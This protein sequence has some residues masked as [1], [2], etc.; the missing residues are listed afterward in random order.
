MAGKGYVILPPS[1]H[2]ETGKQYRWVDSAVPAAQLP[3]WLARLLQPPP[4][5]IHQ[6]IVRSNG[7]DKYVQAALDGEVTD[8]ATAIKGQRNTA[9]NVAAV[10]LGTLVGAGILSESDVCAA[11]TDASHVNGYI[12]DKGLQAAEKTIRSGLRYGMARPRVVS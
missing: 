4:V 1:F 3:G 2:H 10:K 6:P 8:V 11:L 9:L 12:G 7:T 5:P